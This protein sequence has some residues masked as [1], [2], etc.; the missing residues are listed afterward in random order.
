MSAP[1][2]NP[3]PRLEGNPS[4]T[5][6]VSGR[7]V[8][9]FDAVS[10]RTVLRSCE[11][12]PP[13]QVVRAF[14]TAEGGALVHLNNLSGG[15]LGGDRLLLHVE[16][17][18]GTDVQ[19]TSTG[20]TRVYRCRD[21]VE[22][23]CQHI[24]VQVAAN[25]LLEYLPDPVIPFAGA[26]YRQETRIDLEL[27]AGLFWWETLA[28]GREAH[29]EL[30]AY[31]LLESSLSVTSQGTP[32]ALERWRLEPRLRPLHSPARLGP[33]RYVTTFTICRVGL[34]PA[35]WQALEAQL[36]DLAREWTHPDEAVWGVSALPAHG[37]TVRGL[38]RCG[39]HIAPGL[40]AFWRTAKRALYGRNAVAPR[41]VY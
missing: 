32:L 28:P 16:A 41:K 30:F 13:L 29:G 10:G 35:A 2:R 5:E 11:Q 31:D 38:S 6:G 22:S 34:E 8:L 37:L 33:Y 19:L 26:R 17:G 21:D 25:A 18:P 20:A 4:R 7:L 27:G 15:V 39:R 3:F 9:R 14:P 36:A 40:L 24:D 23:A 1:V 12:R